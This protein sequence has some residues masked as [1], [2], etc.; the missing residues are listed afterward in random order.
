AAKDDQETL[1]RINLALSLDAQQQAAKVK[2]LANI[3]SKV[4]VVMFALA[5]LCVG[6]MG[7]NKLGTAYESTYRDTSHDLDGLLIATGSF[8]GLGIMIF[9]I[10][11]LVH[12]R[13][14]TEK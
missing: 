10:A 2:N 7:L 4:S 6:F 9:L 12:I 5:G 14:N 3:L 8:V 11:Q 13:A 1:E